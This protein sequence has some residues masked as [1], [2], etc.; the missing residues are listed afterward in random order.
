M[1]AKNAAIIQSILEWIIVLIYLP[2]AIVSFLVSYIELS[3]RWLLEQRDYLISKIGH[4]LF[5]KCDEKDIVKNKS[6][7]V[8]F[9][10]KTLYEFLKQ[11]KK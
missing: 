1:K 8:R 6:Y 9:T 5:L 11:Q 2:F 10:A 4:T 7:Y 3:F